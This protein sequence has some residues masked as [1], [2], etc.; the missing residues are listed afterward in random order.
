MN[1][2]DS[3]LDKIINTGK[4]NSATAMIVFAVELKSQGEKLD[5]LK[6]AINDDNNR[7]FPMKD[8]ANLSSRVDRLENGALKILI[9]IA[10][11]VF[12]AVI[13]LVIKG[14]KL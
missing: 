14:G 9:T 2:T 3:E 11:I 1:D 6:I 7:Y 12:L 8:G 13:G 4:I 10:G 5:N